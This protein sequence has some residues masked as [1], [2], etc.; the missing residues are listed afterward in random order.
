[1]SVARLKKPDL[2]KSEWAIEQAIDTK[3]VIVTAVHDASSFTSALLFRHTLTTTK[4][5]LVSFAAQTGF[6]NWCMQQ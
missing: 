3:P 1:M 2:L 5:Q 6:P 4:S